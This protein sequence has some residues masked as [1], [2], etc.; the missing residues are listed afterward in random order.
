MTVY[1][2]RIVQEKDPRTSLRRIFRNL[3]FEKYVFSRVEPIYLVYCYKRFM[4]ERERAYIR[5]N[6]G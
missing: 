4:H 3:N 6:T 1:S 2:L 5:P